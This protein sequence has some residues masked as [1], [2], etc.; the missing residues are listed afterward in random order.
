M[1]WTSA[2]PLS[3]G[4][5]AQDYMDRAA[6]RIAAKVDAYTLSRVFGVPYVE[7][8]EPEVFD[9]PRLPHWCGRCESSGIPK[10]IQLGGT[11]VYSEEAP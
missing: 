7:P 6:A 4:P 5:K 8:V 10:P 2:S 1:A 11:A 9:H 3:L